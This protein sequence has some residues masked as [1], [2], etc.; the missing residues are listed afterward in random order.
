MPLPR[1]SAPS[2]LAAALILLAGVLHA[3]LAVRAMRDKSTTADELAHVTGGYTFNVLGDYRM[4]PENGLL[5]QRWQ[6]LPASVA[7]AAYPKLGTPDWQVSDVW[8]TGHAF[9]YD[10]GNDTEWLLGSARAMNS[11]F[12]LMTVLLVGGWAWRIFGRAGA[13]VAAAFCAFEPTMLAHSGLATSDMAMAFF[14]LASLTAFWVHLHRSGWGW[15]A[16]SALV[17]GLACVAKYSAVLLPPMFVGLGFLRALRLE[18]LPW[19]GR[20]LPSVGGKLAAIAASIAAHGLVAVGVIWAFCG[21]R[22]AAFNPALPPGEFSFPF[23]AA[24]SG[25]GWQADIISL[26]RSWH[27]LPEAF[28]YGFAFVLKHA[29]QR[30]AFLDGDYSLTGWPEFFPKAFLYKTTPALLVAL[31]LS[32]LL[33]VL[34]SRRRGG[35]A[36]GARLYPVLPLGLLFATY[37]VVSLTSRLNIGHRHILPT[38]PVLAIAVGALGWAVVRAWRD[39]RAGG[40]AFAVVLLAVG[41]WQA[42]AVAGIF[43]HYLAYF[44]PVAGGPENGYRH[45]VDSSLDWGQD[46]PGLRTWLDAHRRTGEPLYLSYF[47]T[48][49]PAHQGIKATLMPTLPGFGRKRPWYWLEPGLYAT[50]AT[51]LQHAYMKIRGPWTAANEQR[52]QELRRNEAN[53]RAIAAGGPA[54]DALLAS[55]TRAEWEY[56]W[57][58][59][60]QLRFARLCHYLRVRRPDASIGYSILVYRLTREELDA[61]L[62]G[63]IADLAAA[64]ARAEQ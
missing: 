31:V 15:A 56:A 63:S 40:A 34:W 53:F 36:L 9:F 52:Y 27:L 50:S 12:G 23:D 60:E 29:T 11:V 19:A 61:A 28:L 14:F 38:Y 10:L 44:S 48:G 47:G 41:G 2:L 46:L 25:L 6:A 33:L 24:L 16:L 54:A 62:H 45:L 3:A 5:P 58:V 64:V 20:T 49:E 22:F 42:S 17:F 21:F 37:W 55:A 51:M 32:G 7:G 57:D 8:L 39:G 30:G 4:H 35:A 18:P 59:Y 26:C 13:L 1:P 43:P